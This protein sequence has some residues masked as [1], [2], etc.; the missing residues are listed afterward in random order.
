LLDSHVKPTQPEFQ[1]GD[2]RMPD[3]MPYLVWRHTRNMQLQTSKIEGY[4]SFYANVKATGPCT[5]VSVGLMVEPVFH[6]FF[7][8]GCLYIPSL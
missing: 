2:P 1:P 4:F 3:R 7:D 5:H 8:F 6:K